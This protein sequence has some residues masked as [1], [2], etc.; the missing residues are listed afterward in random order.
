MHPKR[1]RGEK[2]TTLFSSAVPWHG[3]VYIYVGR[4]SAYLQKRRRR[5]GGGEEEDRKETS[6]PS[7]SFCQ[8]DLRH[9]FWCVCKWESGGGKEKSF[10]S[11]KLPC[12]PYLYSSL[13]SYCPYIQHHSPRKEKRG[14]FLFIF[15]GAAA[16]T[17]GAC[18]PPPFRPYRTTCNLLSFSLRFHILFPRR[19][20]PL[21]VWVE[22]TKGVFALAQRWKKRAGAEMSLLPQQP[23]QPRGREKG[24]GRTKTLSSTS[25]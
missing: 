6:F 25:N 18:S 15:A 8:E 2:G 11:A 13:L 14:P 21:S 12:L 4:R 20:H 24:V 19:F 10:S 23:P 9:F 17:F 5:K 16:K 3:L 7:P 1:R 22:R